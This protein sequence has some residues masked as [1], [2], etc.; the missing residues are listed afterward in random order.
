MILWGEGNGRVNW[1]GVFVL[2]VI[3]KFCDK[4][5]NGVGLGCM[6][7]KHCFSC[8]GSQGSSRPGMIFYSSC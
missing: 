5:G 1:H 7:G 3:A 4:Y 2:G 8:E 6:G